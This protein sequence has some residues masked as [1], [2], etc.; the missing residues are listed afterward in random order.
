[1]VPFDVVPS[2]YHGDEVETVVGDL[3]DPAT[4]RAA[5]EGCD[6]PGGCTQKENQGFLRP[7]AHSAVILVS[8]RKARE[9]ASA[10][11]F[12]IVPPYN[13]P[14]VIAGQGTIGVE[15]VRQLRPLD[16]VFVA[17]GGGG[18]ISGIAAYLKSASPRTTIVGC[19]PRNSRVLYE[20]IRAGRIL[21]FPEQPTISDGTAGGIEPGS[22][23]FPLT[24][25]LIDRHVLVFEREIWRA[26]RL[27][28]FELRPPALEKGLA[29][30]LQTRL[31]TVESRCGV[32]ADLRRAPPRARERHHPP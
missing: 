8:E 13:D 19:W 27:L 4:A 12:S 23:T 5:L 9:L 25:A 10:E 7:D 32:R 28:I 2:P 29:D 21:E 26:M 31:D 22:I 1:M 6:G 3:C 18:L 14:A 16:A 11:G 24:R 20:S 30:A 17:V 15:L